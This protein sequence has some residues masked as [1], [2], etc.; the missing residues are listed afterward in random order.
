MHVIQTAGFS[1]SV[2]TES[3]KLRK[4]NFGLIYQTGPCIFVT[5]ADVYCISGYS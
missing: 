4:C 2:F 3:T 1:S 5:E